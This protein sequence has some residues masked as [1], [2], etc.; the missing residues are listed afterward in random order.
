[1]APTELY[2]YE[3]RP[4]QVSGLRFTGV[5]VRYGIQVSQP[6]RRNRAAVVLPHRPF[7]TKDPIGVVSAGRLLHG[8][9]IVS[10]L[11][12]RLRRD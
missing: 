12:D 5:A 10:Y 7:D 11:V 6:A 9:R 4:N 8:H 3:F 1:M 2:P